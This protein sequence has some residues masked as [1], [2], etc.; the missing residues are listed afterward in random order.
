MKA[1][2]ANLRPLREMRFYIVKGYKVKLSQ[3]ST[4]FGKMSNEGDSLLFRHS[5]LSHSTGTDEFRFSV[6]PQQPV[7]ISI[8]AKT[9]RLD[10]SLDDDSIPSALIPFPVCYPPAN[11]PIHHYPMTFK[12]SDEFS[13]RL[14]QNNHPLHLMERWCGQSVEIDT[15]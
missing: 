3:M 11:I 15:T 12:G 14:F 5:C 10:V 9:R 7:Q 4:Y 6:T 13:R 8:C 1:L 2:D